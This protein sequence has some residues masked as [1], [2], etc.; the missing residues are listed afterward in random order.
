MVE[1]KRSNDIVCTDL[2]KMLS[3]DAAVEFDPTQPPRLNERVLKDKR[4]KLR[5]TFDR[6]INMYVSMS[7]VCAGLAFMLVLLGFHLSRKTA[8]TRVGTVLGTGTGTAVFD[9]NRRK[10]KPQFFTVR[11]TVFT[12]F[13][14]MRLYG[15]ARCQRVPFRRPNDL[16]SIDW[17]AKLTR[18]SL[19]DCVLQP[20]LCRVRPPPFPPPP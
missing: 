17:Y 12:Q 10:P 8:K 11:D 1:A 20:P 13:L 6:V 18:P 5:E 15:Q 9:Q 3:F 4:K 2:G 14:V 19:T 16:L 7:A